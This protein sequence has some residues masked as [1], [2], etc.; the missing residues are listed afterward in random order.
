VA[1]FLDTKMVADQKACNSFA[2][3]SRKDLG[4]KPMRHD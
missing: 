1:R 2:E 4:V 3:L